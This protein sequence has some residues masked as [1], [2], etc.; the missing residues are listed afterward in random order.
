MKVTIEY[1][2]NESR[3]YDVIEERGD[4]VYFK[5]Y[6]E[7]RFNTKTKQVQALVDG[8]WMDIYRR[9]AYLGAWKG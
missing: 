9:K 6:Y 7:M 3:T 4:H 2:R 8:D 1:N 5:G